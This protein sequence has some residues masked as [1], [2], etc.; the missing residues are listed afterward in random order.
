MSYCDEF[1]ITSIGVFYVIGLSDK[2][3]YDFMKKLVDSAQD[4][5]YWRAL[6]NAGLNLRVP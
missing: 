4:R 1:V 3:I 5:N 2:Q 6:M